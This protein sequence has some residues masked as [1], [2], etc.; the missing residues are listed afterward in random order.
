MPL[1]GKGVC[2]GE[3][4]EYAAGSVSSVPLVGGECASGWVGSM[5]RVV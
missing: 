2:I 1:V 4:R 3:G 5:P